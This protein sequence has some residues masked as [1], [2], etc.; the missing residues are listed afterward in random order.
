MLHLLRPDRADPPLFLL[1]SLTLLTCSSSAE[2]R[3]APRHASHEPEPRA[4][5][6][7]CARRRGGAVLV[8]S[9]R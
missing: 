5:A 9:L 8:L 2:A 1:Y 3:A 4:T 6:P 7:R